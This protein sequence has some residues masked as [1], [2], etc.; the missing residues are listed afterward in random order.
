MVASGVCK[1]QPK[2]S[3]ACR[4]GKLRTTAHTPVSSSGA[5]TTP[6]QCSS[7]HLDCC[8][9]VECDGD[10]AGTAAFANTAVPAAV[11]AG[12]IWELVNQDGHVAPLHRHRLLTGGG[13]GS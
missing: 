2:P 5:N 3:N 12:R 9:P 4:Y 1:E 6:R 13:G 8:C 10:F 11:A 7:S